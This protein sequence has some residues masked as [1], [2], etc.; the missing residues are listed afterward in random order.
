MDRTSTWTLCK[1]TFSKWNDHEAP[2]LGAALAFYSVLSLAPLVILITAI[3]ALVFGNRAAQDQILAQV[4]DLLGHQGA[5]TV[6]GILASTHQQSS[7]IVAA[8]V[9]L[10]TLLLGAS[11]V[12]AELQSA[13][14]KIWA[15][16]QP[17][18]NGI[19]E[20]IRARLFSCGM[21][22][23]FGFLLLVS[24]FLSAGIVAIA[25]FF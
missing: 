22:L 15:A 20:M 5:R 12:F 17:A 19:V 11:G 1:N 9:G 7:G 3:V 6:Q 2:R 24:L 25:T 16:K 18:R 21:V 23:A 10:V 8:I 13:L 4:E 14:N